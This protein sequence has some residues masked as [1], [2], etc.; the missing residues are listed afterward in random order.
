MSK[1]L[2]EHHA[3]PSTNRYGRPISTP[4][5]DSVLWSYIVQIASAIKTVHAANL[6]IRCLDPTKII[7]TDKNRIRINACSILDVVKFGEQRSLP[8]LQQDDMKN[9][10]MLILGLGVNNLSASISVK[11]AI[12]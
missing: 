7:L 3:T 1:T 2:A 8:D 10:G 9:L 4:V 12:E 5:A 11:N 6:A